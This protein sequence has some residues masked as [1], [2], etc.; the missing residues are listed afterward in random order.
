M[1]LIE[2]LSLHASYTWAVSLEMNDDDGVMGEM[3]KAYFG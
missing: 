3:S 2:K 1:W